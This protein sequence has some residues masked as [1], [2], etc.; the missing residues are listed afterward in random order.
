MDLDNK[1]AHLG[2]SILNDFTQI[3]KDKQPASSAYIN[4]FTNIFNYFY[5][6]YIKNM[7]NLE[8]VES[9]KILNELEPILA[10]NIEILEKSTTA[11]S[12]DHKKIE[13]LRKKRNKLMKIY[14]DKLKIELENEN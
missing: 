3:L 8:Q 5:S 10:C 12:K 7:K 9:I 14:T 1:T 2:I 11:G 13:A 4:V 6:L